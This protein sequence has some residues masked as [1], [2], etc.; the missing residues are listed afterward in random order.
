MP[1]WLF[2]SLHGY[3]RQWLRGDLIAGLAVW[4]VLV[5]ESLAYASLAGVSPV[6]GLYA[7]PGALVLYAAFGSSRHLITGLGAATSALSAATVGAF[8]AGGSSKFVLMSAALAVSAGVILLAAGL[9][10]LGFIASFISEPVLKG[11]IAGLALTIIVGQL[12]T[13]LG[14]PPSSGDF[15]RKLWEL[16][17]KLGDAQGLTVLV[18]VS[19]LALVLGLKRFA[20]TVPGALAAVILGVAIVE[21]FALNEHGVAIVGHITRGLPSL[22]IPDLSA[23]EYLRLAGAG[24]GVT[25]V[26]FVEGLSAAK[27]YAAERDYAVDSNREL[28]GNGTASLAAGLSGGIIVSGSLTKTAV[29]G[30][31]GANTQ[32]SG[33]MVAA[34]TIVTLLVLIGPFEALPQAT[35]AAIVVAALVGLVDVQAF[36]RLWR[37]YTRRLGRA[38]GVA[39]RPDFIAAFATLLGVTVFSTLTGLFIGIAA[40]LILL[41]YHVSRPRVARL[42]KVPGT[43][44]QYAD[45]EGHPDNRPPPGIA[46]VR[47]EAGLFFANADLVSKRLHE[48]AS[49]DGVKAVVLDAETMPFLDV[50]AVNMLDGTERDLSRKGVRLLVARDIGPVRDILREAGADEALTYFYPSVQAAVEAIEAHAQ[51][52]PPPQSD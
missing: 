32:L 33:I 23:H 50:T 41:L 43:D 13:L 15:F 10:R 5:P 39:V 34:L 45:I 31:A 8:A 30:S 22:G 2:S 16:I 28:I 9:L 3:R 42:G 37:V 29:N 35:L 44:D 14:I 47:V 25:L 4:A 24:V 19:S 26:G 38:Y 27:A 1:A 18:G 46:I 20:P 12:F 51:L 21:V 36:I 17:T 7:A 6:V 11:F 48:A 49:S 52:T 40:S